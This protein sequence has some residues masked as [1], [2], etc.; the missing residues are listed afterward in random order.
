MCKCGIYLILILKIY[1]ILFVVDEE[2]IKII[3]WI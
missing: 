3:K 2:K 1:F